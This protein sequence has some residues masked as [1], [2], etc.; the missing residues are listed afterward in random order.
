MKKEKL[1][2][3]LWSKLKKSDPHVSDIIEVMESCPFLVNRGYLYLIAKGNFESRDLFDALDS[4]IPYKIKLKI[5]RRLIPTS[6]IRDLTCIA[7]LMPKLS[8]EIWIHVFG[9]I[10]GP[11]DMIMALSYE[12]YG[13]RMLDEILERKYYSYLKDFIVTVSNHNKKL[14]ERAARVLLKETKSPEVLFRVAQSFNSDDKIYKDLLNKGLSNSSHQ[15]ELLIALKLSGNDDFQEE[16]V[17]RIL[18]SYK[19]TI[20][21][22]SLYTIIIGNMFG[23][24]K[25]WKIFR[26]RFKKP[27]YSSGDI[28]FFGVCYIR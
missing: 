12:K 14:A 24:E 19:H 15:S 26:S 28:F 5:A 11:R 10:E 7:C 17:S 13:K 3:S 18:S 1:I 9:Q 22:E 6:D 4:K 23:A 27:T 2:L 16:I 21:T 25:A 20:S 8:G